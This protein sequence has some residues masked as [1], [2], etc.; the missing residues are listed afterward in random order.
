MKRHDAG[1][2]G[3]AGLLDVAAMKHVDHPR[4]ACGGLETATR[5]EVRCR[6]VNHLSLWQFAEPVLNLLDLLAKL[7]TPPTSLGRI[8]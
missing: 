3:F 1:C 7:I 5:L 2:R 8:D 4:F 6:R